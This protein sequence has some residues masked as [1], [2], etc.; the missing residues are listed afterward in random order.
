MTGDNA[1]QAD[2]VAIS[3]PNRLVVFFRTRYNSCKAFCER[4]D[5]RE[6]LEQALAAVTGEP[7]RLEFQLLEDPTERAAE[8]PQ[9]VSTR[10]RIR[11]ANSQPVVRQAIELFDA[12]VLRVEEPRQPVGQA[13]VDRR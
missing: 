13:G 12:E 3:A 5:R 1:S 10:Q 8:K 4:P 11:Q 9:P 6:K 2:H 7:I